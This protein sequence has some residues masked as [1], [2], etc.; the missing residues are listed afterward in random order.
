MAF[1]EIFLAGHGR[2][3]RAGKIAPSCPFGW[4]ITAQDLIHLVRSRSQL[5]NKKVYNDN[6]LSVLLSGAECWTVTQ[7]DR[8]RLSGFHTSCLRK[9]C[10]IYW[11]KKITNKELYQK[12][13]KRD[14][15]T[16]MAVITQREVEMT[17]NYSQEMPGQHHK[18][19]I[20]VDTAQWKKEARPAT[21]NVEEND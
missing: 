6:V 7:R 19:C 18:N 12:T 13:G 5:Y 9:I 4:P 16:V 20:V 2:Q 3:S 21:R 1:R 17:W 8:R 10:R 14:I 15:T 11:P